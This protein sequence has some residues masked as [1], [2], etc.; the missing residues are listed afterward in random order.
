MRP[1]PRFARLLV[2]LAT[3]LYVSLPVAAAGP[4]VAGSG[5]LR[6]TNGTAFFT[7]DLDDSRPLAFTYW[8]FASE[9]ARMLDFSELAAVDCL[10]DLFG[11]QALRL[12]GAGFDSSMPGESVTLQVFLVDAL[13]GRPDRLSLKVTRPNG[14]ILYFAP[15]RELESGDLSISC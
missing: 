11:G 14:A 3:A 15:L 13:D 2:G 5:A 1:I 8:D 9:P 6:S 4:R 12:T 10:G 7:V